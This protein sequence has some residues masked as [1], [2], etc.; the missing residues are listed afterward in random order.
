[1][2]HIDHI[3]RREKELLRLV[4]SMIQTI[5]N[6]L[7]IFRYHLY[8]GDI[9]GLYYAEQMERDVICLLE[10]KRK[11]IQIEIANQMEIAKQSRLACITSTEERLKR[12]EE[13]RV[14]LH[15]IT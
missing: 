9:S 3:I 14:Y 11:R 7:D 5:D 10:K 8:P 15:T 12:F 6:E 1:M 4:T 2:W 13:L